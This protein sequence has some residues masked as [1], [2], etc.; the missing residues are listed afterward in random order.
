VRKTVTVVFCDM[1]DSTPLGE[2]LDPESLRGVQRLW[3]ESMRTALQRYGGTV[4]K[5]IGDAVMAVFGLPF[6]HEDDA[7][8]AVR[9]AAD[10]RVALGA[11]N[12]ELNRDLGVE[13]QVRTAVHT[14]EVVAGDGETLVTGDAVNVAARLEQNAK[15]GEILLGERTVQLLGQAATVEPAPDLMVK[16]KAEP[17]GAWRLISVLPDVP[18]FTRPIATPFVGRR[19][20]L[21]LLEAKFQSVA[22]ASRCEQVTVL[23]PPGIGKSRLLR[24]AVASLGT[25]ARVAVGRCVPFGEGVTYFPLA[26]IVKQVAGDEP[27]ARL[28]ELLRPDENAE[29][30]AEMVAAA[31][32][33]SERGGS[34]EE[35][36]WAIRTLL[37]AMARDRPLVVVVEDLHWAEATF[38]DLIEYV[39]GFSRERQI[40]FLC[41]G[42]PELLETRPTWA[43]PAE[44]AELLLLQPLAE[45]EV[46]TLVDALLEDR[47]F[48]ETTRS[49]VLDA[50]EGNPLFV[51]QLVAM[52][53]EVDDAD[54]ELVVPPTLQA[55][56]AERIDRLEVAERAVLECAA[57]EGR[58]FHR[59][60]VVEFLPAGER[61]AVGAR[62]LALMRKGFVRP[63]RSEF[64]DD[65]GFRFVHILIRDA[66][67][68]S[69]AKQMR[70]E[71]HERYADWLEKKVGERI[72]EYEEIVGYHLEQAHF[73]RREL[74]VVPEDAQR[75]A[76]RASNRLGAA[77]RRAYFRGDLQAAVGLLSRAAA[78]L[79]QSAGERLELLVDLG[80]ALRETGDF[81]QSE[82]VLT[83]VIEVAGD[84][85]LRAR[86]L[87]NRLR[88]RVLI[89]PAVVGV[90]AVEAKQVVDTFQSAGDE[91]LLAKAWELL[92]W[93][94]WFRCQAAGTERALR[95]AIEHARRA[96]DTLTEAHCLHL[97]CA[98]ALFGPM[99]ISEAIDLCEEIRAR[100]G[101]QRRIIASAVRALAGLQA[102]GGVFQEAR[103][104]VDQHKAI[105]QEFDLRVTAASAAETYGMVEMLASDPVAAEREFT[106]GYEILHEIGE[107]NL[108]PDLAA[109]R[110]RAMYA[111][112][113]Y[114][115]ADRFTRVCEEAASQ[116]DTHGQILWR[117]TRAKVRARQGRMAEGDRLAR[118]AVALAEETDFPVLL[119]DAFLALGEVLLIGAHIDDAVAAA[120]QALHFY[121]SKGNAVSADAARDMLDELHATASG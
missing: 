6:A 111:Q 81:E 57:V 1:V 67:Y 96:S 8:R 83:N 60:A 89:S 117:L 7:L 80:E 39:V 110:A 56:L 72:R 12:A 55:L 82:T 41:S 5:F 22:A 73:Y 106:R 34:T 79:E 94:S 103:A 77:G 78:L 11:M 37:E 49:R 58:R 102:M 115:E 90:V 25:R 44:K 16:G 32:G 107:G 76:R 45:R 3:H 66:T 109:M 2:R 26:E 13:I 120:E 105:L 69:I 113:R 108:S 9:A 30:A 24:E 15:G 33:A 59:G 47:S 23:G 74:G 98:A 100:P 36:H 93:V 61:A 48:P 63:D 71:L 99:A 54:D 87:V 29:L 21:A 38:L 40:L 70:A 50:A 53:I 84:P 4:E 20:E 42:R 112:G 75:L 31:V 85:I 64:P 91:R 65:D 118:D 35:T 43:T 18:A 104:L 101:Q 119:G 86:A 95:R 97:L 88:L 121:E 62:L 92:A 28:V 52:H 116:E 68:G 14:G 10:M 51:E 19:H 27:R 114:E 46:D 17:I